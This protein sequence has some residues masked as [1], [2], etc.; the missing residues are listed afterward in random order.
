MPDSR[1]SSM[2]KNLKICCISKPHYNYF[3]NEHLLHVH[4]D[5]YRVPNSPRALSPDVRPELF[6][7]SL[8]DIFAT[9]PELKFE[10]E[11]SNCKEHRYAKGKAVY[12]TSRKS[13]N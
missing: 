1:M 13:A 3:E 8:T 6:N 2:A 10:T 5:K 7:I 4:Y 11:L 9:L 12:Y